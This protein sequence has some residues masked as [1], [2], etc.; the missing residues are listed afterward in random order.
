VMVMVMVMVMA[1]VMLVVMVMAAVVRMCRSIQPACSARPTPRPRRMA[2]AT[3]GLPQLPV[4]V[5]FA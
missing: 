4:A 2:W 1:M 3:T 5:L